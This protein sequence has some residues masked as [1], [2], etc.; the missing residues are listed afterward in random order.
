MHM[1]M[2]LIL[3]ATLFIMQIV[4]FKWQQMHN[5][6]YKVCVLGCD[7]LLLLFFSNFIEFF[8]ENTVAKLFIKMLNSLE[9]VKI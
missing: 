9:S 4:L 3:F 5:R 1:E 8:I 6:S 7:F 2:V